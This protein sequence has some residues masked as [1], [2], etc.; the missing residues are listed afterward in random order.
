MEEEVKVDE[1][2]EKNDGERHSGFKEENDQGPKKRKE[3][4]EAKAEKITPEKQSKEKK[5]KVNSEEEKVKGAGNEN[6]DKNPVGGVFVTSSKCNDLKIQGNQLYQSFK[7]AF[8]DANKIS[9]LHRALHCYVQGHAL[10]KV[11][12]RGPNGYEMQRALAK[13]RGLVYFNLA[14]LNKIK[15]SKR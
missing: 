11:E 9:F 6:A 8:G 4:E 1:G 10:V 14:I 2:N 5:K 13:N 12:M 7:E 15:T 3:R